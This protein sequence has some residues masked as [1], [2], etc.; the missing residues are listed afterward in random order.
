MQHARSMQHFSSTSHSTA[1]RARQH[2]VRGAVRPQQ[3]RHRQARQGPPAPACPPRSAAGA[4]PGAAGARRDRPQPARR[5]RCEPSPHPLN[6]SPGC[7]R[8]RPDAPRG[9]A[10]ADLFERAIALDRRAEEGFFEFGRYLDSLMRDARTRQAAKA[11]RARGGADAPGAPLD[12]LAGRAKCARLQGSHRIFR[13]GYGRLSGFAAARQGTCLEAA[14]GHVLAG[15]GAGRIAP[16]GRPTGAVCAAAAAHVVWGVPAH[17]MQAQTLSPRRAPRQAGGPGR[18]PAV[19]RNPAG[20][21]ALLRQ[22]RA[23]RPPARAPGAAAHAHRLVRAWRAL[24]RAPAAGHD[25]GAGR[26]MAAPYDA[27]LCMQGQGYGV[28]ERAGS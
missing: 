7:A 19:H 20:G 17:V 21:A 9:G 24:P 10:R 1:V 4:Q 23:P 12:R 16:Q 22:L 2:S 5:A 14:A 15:C 6:G 8:R 11:A 25:A 18:G 28:C 26:A 3:P 27:Q 13:P